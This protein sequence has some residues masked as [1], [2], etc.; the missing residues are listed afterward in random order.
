[1]VVFLNPFVIDTCVDQNEDKRIRTIQCVVI[2][3]AIKLIIC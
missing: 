2:R 3:T 1:M